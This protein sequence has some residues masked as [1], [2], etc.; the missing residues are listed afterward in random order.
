M[1]KKDIQDLLKS[2]GR[3][4]GQVFATDIEYVKNNFGEDGVARLKKKIEEWGDP[5]DYSKI[6]VMGWYPIGWRVLSLLAMKEVFNWSNKEI[7]E[8]GN[9]APKYSFIVRL[10]MKYF[11]TPKKT[12]QESSKYW[13]K[14][15][16][17]GELDCSEFN[18][19]KRYGVI[20]LKNFKI[21]PI[22]CEFYKGY[23]LRIAQYV[24]KGDKVSIEETKCP[25]SGENYY[26]FLIKW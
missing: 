20:R 22:L 17:V 24:L 13:Q 8:F 15:Y 21:H 5:F 16:S 14:H 26:E 18:G 12:F 19:K 10:M 7:F 2:E 23:F 1:D 4:R 3:A 25:F 9:S 11:L 6:K